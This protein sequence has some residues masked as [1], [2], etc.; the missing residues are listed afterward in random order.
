MKMILR[1]LT[2]LF[3]FVGLTSGCQDEV[4]KD[5]SILDKANDIIAA[6]SSQ[7]N[8]ACFLVDDAITYPEPWT[9]EAA[10]TFTVTED[11]LNNTSTCGLI[12]TFL[13]QPWNIL[14]P[15]CSTCSN[16]SMDGMQYFNDRINQ[17]KVISELFSREDGL[18]KLIGKY[19]S[20][21]QDLKSW[22]E[23]PGYLYSYEILL[24]SEKMNEILADTI[25]KE[26]MILSMK[27]LDI[28][29]G[30]SEF[31]HENSIA[32]TRHIL[33]N[34]LVQKNF[35]PLFSDYMADGFLETFI[36]GYKICYDGD[37]VETYAKMYLKN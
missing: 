11:S 30:N 22:E 35:E 15:W 5:D 32:I 16:L 6:Y 19:V 9:E 36:S 2:S 27:M 33:V 4:G 1:S 12:Q 31:L 20:I 29:K 34:I 37:K 13:N 14:G 23:H 8:F 17:D 24:A 7:P 28:K 26:L 10:N 21:I 3:L 18:D 25:S